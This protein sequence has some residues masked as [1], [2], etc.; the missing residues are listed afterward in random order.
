MPHTWELRIGCGAL[1]PGR[2]LL[3]VMRPVVSNPLRLGQRYSYSSS[4][5]VVVAVVVVLVA[6]VAAVAVERVD[7]EKLARIDSFRMESYR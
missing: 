1:A 2:A 7:L 4:V 5:V 6:P 3:I